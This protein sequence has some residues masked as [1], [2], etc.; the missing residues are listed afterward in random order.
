MGAA[1]ARAALLMGAQVIVIAGPSAVAYPLQSKVISVRTAMDMLSA[2]RSQVVGCDFV[3]GTAAV[4]DYRPADPSSTKIRRTE[5]SVNLELI[6]NPDVIAILALEN[7]GV[8]AI[9]FAAEPSTGLDEVRAKLIRKKLFAIAANDISNRE[10]G[11]ESDVNEI[12]LVRAV[13]EE[14]SGRRSKLGCALWLLERVVSDL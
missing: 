5:G 14:I 4:A 2:A 11:F 9:G 3:V 10:I 12:T 1:V 13:G 7:P 8:L 6:P